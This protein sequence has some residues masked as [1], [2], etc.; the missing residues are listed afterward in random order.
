[1]AITNFLNLADIYNQSDRMAAA[2][3]ERQ[4]RGYQLADLARVERE[5]MTLESLA[6]QSQTPEGELDVEQ[7]AAGAGRAGLWKPAL[8]LRE[9]AQTQ[10]ATKYKLTEAHAEVLG[11]LAVGVKNDA[12]YQ[13]VLAS[14]DAVD[15]QAATKLRETF[16]A[17]TPE[18]A[19]A[20][21]MIGQQ[22]MT[23][24]QREHLAATERVARAKTEATGKPKLSAA[25]ANSIRANLLS[26]L[27]VPF[28]TDAAGNT[29]FSALDPVKD[30]KLSQM[31]MRAAE[32]V[33]SGVDK[34]TAPNLAYQEVMGGNAPS[35]QAPNVPATGKAPSTDVR[36]E[37]LR[38][39]GEPANRK[40]ILERLKAQGIDTSFLP[41]SGSSG[42]ELPSATVKPA[43]APVDNRPL[44]ERDYVEP[45]SGAATMGRAAQRLEALRQ[46]TRSAYDD[47]LKKP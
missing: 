21:Q 40:A 9:K 41:G 5:R 15:P 46:Q 8:D 32:L 7:M 12:E 31:E 26:K 25:D 10:K 39:W 30:R 6:Q 11:R 24:Y 18:A 4:L 43:A 33:L 35:G 38:K 36:A 45:E 16:P 44:R 3:Q 23:A 19:R 28:K 34:L 17:W 22:G 2:G 29:V 20:I 42:V 14:F 47:Y 37:A 13:Q 1:M 27:N